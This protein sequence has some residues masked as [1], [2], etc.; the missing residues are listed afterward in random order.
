MTEPAPNPSPKPGDNSP[1]AHSTL[2]ASQTV[3]IGTALIDEK[4]VKDLGQLAEE[5]LKDPVKVKLLSDRVFQ[6][7]KQD[8]GYQLER[9]RGYGRRF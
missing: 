1:V 4:S 2:V 5:L 7:L 6:L 3:P 8:M 9:D